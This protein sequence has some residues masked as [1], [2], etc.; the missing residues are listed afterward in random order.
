MKRIIYL[1]LILA[2]TVPLAG[3]GS[4]DDAVA[5]AQEDAQSASPSPA[6]LTLTLDDDDTWDGTLDGETLPDEDNVFDDG[7]DDEPE[8]TPI[9]EA[10]PT[11]APT[12]LMSTEIAIGDYELVDYTDEAMGIS[13]KVPSHWTVETTSTTLSFTE[14]VTGDK[15][16]MRLALTIKN[17]TEDSLTTAQ[18]KKE[19]NSYVKVIKDSYDKFKS[20]KLSNKML[21]MNRASLSGTYTAKS[22]SST[23]KGYIT[24]CA[25]PRTKQIV[26]LHYSATQ[27]KY[28]NSKSIFRQMLYSVAAV[29]VSVT[30]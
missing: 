14:P 11:P 10:T 15:I 8:S 25:V 24:M 23:I 27:K 16:P 20:G 4:S 9:V 17:Y 19:F 12:P 13:L 22:G 21:F 6:A 26:A 7:F 29:G 2:L 5:P 28:K 1:I 30:E 18:Q 3:C